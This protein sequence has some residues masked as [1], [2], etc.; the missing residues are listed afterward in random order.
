[1]ARFDSLDK[2]PTAR[3]LPALK[4]LV[5]LVGPTAV[6]KTEA[7]IQLARRLDGEI[8]SA[9]SRSFYRGMDIGTAK[10]SLAERKEI[11]HHLVDVA[12]PDEVWSL[13]RF[14]AAARLAIT[15]IHARGCLPFLA[16]GTGQYIRAVIEGWEVPHIAPDTRLRDAL[17]AWAVQIGQEGLHAWPAWTRRLPARSP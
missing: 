13:A 8:V 4:P 15:G 1:M 7:V 16:G 5:I 14:Q 10:P 3:R 12:E 6:G 9:D 11:P 17:E 2:V